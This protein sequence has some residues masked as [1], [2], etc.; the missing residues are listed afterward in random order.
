MYGQPRS[1]LTE[2]ELI[3]QLRMAEADKP[4]EE[5]IETIRQR[6]VAIG[7]DDRM[8]KRLRAAAEEGARPEDLV[9]R[10]IEAVRANLTMTR[11]KS[12]FARRDAADALYD[13]LQNGLTI[14]YS[15]EME[16]DLLDAGAGDGLLSMIW[17]PQPPALIRGQVKEWRTAPVQGPLRNVETPARGEVELDLVVDG[18]VLL[19]LKGPSLF[20]LVICGQNL[21]VK[22]ARYSS[23]LPRLTSSEWDFRIDTGVKNRG[24]LYLCPHDAR[25]R[26][27]NLDKRRSDDQCRWDDLDVED[28]ELGY[29]NA[30]FVIEDDQKGK[31]PYKVLLK[32]ALRPYNEAQLLSDLQKYG[33]DKMKERIYHR[34]VGFRPAPDQ[35][36]K[37]QKL[38]MTKVLI[39]EVRNDYRGGNW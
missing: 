10:V 13:W 15:P 30:R 24:K 12:L 22:N 28:D 27:G 36:E 9:R 39:D 35:I 32:W 29:A 6:T 33:P 34:G 26:E 17:P 21:E 1:P 37:W 18:R 23:S 19:L 8:N 7:W 31:A 2:E 4:S 5:L 25:C 16:R 38:G 3:R 20:H 14:P 11:L